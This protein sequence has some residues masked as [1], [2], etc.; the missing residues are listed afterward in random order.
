MPA[1]QALSAGV[2]AGGEGRSAEHAR[3]SDKKAHVRRLL[4]GVPRF[5]GVAVPVTAVAV[6]M[7]M[8]VKMAVHWTIANEI[9]SLKEDE[10]FLI[11]GRR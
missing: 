2:T 5:N 3:F 9:R 10:L 6:R 4:L 8:Q 7:A 11:P 1:A